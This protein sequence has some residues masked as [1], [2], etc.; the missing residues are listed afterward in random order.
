M[1]YLKVND[2]RLYINL[3]IFNMLYDMGT[4][5]SMKTVV[6]VHARATDAFYKVDPNKI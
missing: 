4:I 2:T 1:M 5:V 6:N 3:S